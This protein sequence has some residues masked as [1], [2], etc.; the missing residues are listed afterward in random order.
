M[1]SRDLVV[2]ESASKREPATGRK[3]SICWG[4]GW[5]QHTGGRHL[6][7]TMRLLSVRL[8][9]SAASAWATDA[10]IL[11]LDRTFGIILVPPLIMIYRQQLRA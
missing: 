5:R 2:M 4:L 6:S 3:S 1:L 10:T 9:R 11:I 7:A 8:L